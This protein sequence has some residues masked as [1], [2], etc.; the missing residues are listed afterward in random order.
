LALTEFTC[1]DGRQNMH[2]FVIVSSIYVKNKRCY[3]IFSDSGKHLVVV[4]AVVVVVLVVVVV[5]N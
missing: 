5:V 2:Y 4:V 1:N 3:F